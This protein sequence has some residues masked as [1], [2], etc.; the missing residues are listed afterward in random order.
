MCKH[1]PV[2]LPGVYDRLHKPREICGIAVI[3]LHMHQFR[4]IHLAPGIPVSPVFRHID[5]VSR[6]QK[7]VCDFVIFFREFAK[8]VG[9]HNTF[10][11]IRQKIAPVSDRHAIF[12]LKIALLAVLFQIRL[13]RLRHPGG[14][15]SLLLFRTASILRHHPCFPCFF[16]TR[17][18]GVSVP[19]RYSAAIRLP[20]SG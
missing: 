20:T 2:F 13:Y 11:R 8:P 6:L 14:I 4:V 3:T 12:H 1:D 17:S 16:I 7:T 15:S 19:S 9:N 10:P 5:R 18:S